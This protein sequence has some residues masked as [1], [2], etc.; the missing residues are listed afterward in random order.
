MILAEESPLRRLPS[1]LNR[2][3]MLFFD[4]IR[5]SIEM[6]DLAH[7]RL[8]QILEEFAS[9]YRSERPPQKYVCAFLEAWSVI[10]SVHRL[11]QL[12]FRLPGLKQNAPGFQLFQRQT[13]DVLDLRNCL[14]HLNKEVEA[15]L[16]GHLPL[17][18]GINWVYAEKA[19]SGSVLS[20]ALIAG[21][22]WGKK[23]GP[24]LVNPCGK[25]I[26]PPVDLITL[27]VSSHRVSLS[28]V[29]N[30]VKAL[31]N[32][33]EKQLQSQFA[34]LPTSAGDLIFF[35]KISFDGEREQP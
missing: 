31:A 35:A 29:M 5:Y 6:A 9:C 17:L 24:Q 11:R 23:K 16:K 14:Q 15:A 10:D 34:G 13:K 19:G 33:I 8:R 18:G 2:K 21:T 22:V 4:A 1:S 28:E 30:A 20:C 25:K 26:F 12:L 27:Q 32:S 7:G 3:Q